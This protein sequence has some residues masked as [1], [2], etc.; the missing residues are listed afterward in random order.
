MCNINTKLLTKL[1][2]IGTTL[3]CCC[4]AQ[5][6]TIQNMHP[7]EKSF[8]LTVEEMLKTTLRPENRQVIV[9]VR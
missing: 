3:N 5:L 7:Q 9:E 2:H 1:P 4:F 8:A 6:P